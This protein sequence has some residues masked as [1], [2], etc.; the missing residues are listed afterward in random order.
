MRRRW[1]PA[2]P[3]HTCARSRQ[4]T[5]RSRRGTRS[6]TRAHPTTWR[7]TAAARR[8]SGRTARLTA[9]AAGRSTR[10]ISAANCP[11]HESHGWHTWKGCRGR[12]TELVERASMRR[13]TTPSCISA[14]T[15]APDA[16]PTSCRIRKS[17]R[18][19]R[20]SNSNRPPAFV[21]ITPNLMHDM[22]DGSVAD[23]DAWLRA[24]LPSVLSSPWF[25]DRGTV[26]ITMDE[27]DAEPS[28]SCCGGAAGGR[29]PMIVIS[30]NARGRGAIATTGDHYGTL[31]TIEEAYGLRLLGEAASAGGDLSAI[32]G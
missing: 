31:R 24:T 7:S 2:R 4:A 10:Q 1:A 12:A 9:G 6:R 23:G 13:S 30:A 29:V 8:E 21:W 25:A 20:R 22:H 19:L 3:I 16:R 28:G 15:A 5:R 27:N 32:F 11:P 17:G 14:P 26:V 18:W